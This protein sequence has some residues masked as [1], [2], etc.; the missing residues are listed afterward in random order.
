MA[1]PVTGQ[2]TSTVQLNQ[3]VGYPSHPYLGG[4]VPTFGPSQFVLIHQQPHELRHSDG[5][6]SVIQL[7]CD[8]LS[9]NVPV[10]G[11]RVLVT[12]NDILHSRPVQAAW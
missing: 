1:T 2:G 5:G 9:D 12:A 10:V 4:N 7:E 3:A 6:M 11:M 8:L